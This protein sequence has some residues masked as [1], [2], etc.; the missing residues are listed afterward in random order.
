MRDAIKRELKSIVGEDRATDTPEHLVTYSYDA[1]TEEHLPDIVLFPLSTDEVS[2]I[3]KVADRESIP[4]TPRGSG[5]NLAGESVPL[6][7]GIVVCL[8]KMDRIVKIDGGNLTATVQPGVVNMDFQKAVEKQGLMY[9]PDP[10]SWAVATMGGTVGTNAG[11]PRTLKYGV[12]KDYLLGLTVVLAN[13]D[14]LNTGGQTIKNVTGYDLTSL[15]CGSEGTLGIVTEII[16]RLVPRPQASR[17][18]RADFARLED[19]SDAVSAIMASGIVPAALELMNQFT[20]RAVEQSSNLGLATDV[21]GILLVQVDGTPQSLEGEVSQIEA[22]L[23]ENGVRTIAK[24]KD[25]EEAER[26]W[27]AR[28]CAAPALMRMRPNTVTED[29]TVPV[30]NLTPMIRKVVEI[31]RRHRI[32]VGVLAHAGDGNLHPCMVFDKRDEDEYSRV[33]AACEDLVPEALALGGTLSGEHGIGIAKAP[34]LPL[35]MDAVALRV[36]QGIKNYFDPKG[37]LNPGKFV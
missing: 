22:V 7:G 36:M 28:R 24:A 33:K 16:V 2:S 21:E 35:V 14:V 17:T 10:A 31:C 12:T 15:M 3:M 6:R 30:A 20:I 1:Y 9:P 27:L 32:D 5:T 8:T 34:F 37:I 25:A 19:C 13:G 23:R 18:L 29:V 4:V 11:G 26:L